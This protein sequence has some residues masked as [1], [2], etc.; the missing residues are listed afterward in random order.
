MN[1]VSMNNKLEK[2][3]LEN[4]SSFLS[5]QLIL[6]FDLIFDNILTLIEM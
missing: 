6:T 5:H 1:E 3:T 4:I 2:N